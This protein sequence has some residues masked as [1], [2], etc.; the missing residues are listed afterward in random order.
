MAISTGWI[1]A[2]EGQVLVPGE[3]RA[4]DADGQG[5]PH[6][7]LHLLRAHQSTG[8]RAWLEGSQDRALIRCYDAARADELEAMEAPLFARFQFKPIARQDLVRTEDGGINATWAIFVSPW[9]APTEKVTIHL[10]MVCF[11]RP[12]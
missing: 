1:P 6:G 10:R 8:L 12:W 2:P 3:C 4:R 5:C 9:I 7:V 11:A